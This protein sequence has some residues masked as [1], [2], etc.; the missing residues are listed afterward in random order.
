MRKCMD[1]LLIGGTRFMGPHIVGQLLKHGH[2]LTVFH[3]GNHPCPLKDQITCIHGDRNGELSKI[4]GS[5]DSVIDTC[6]YHRNQVEDVYG[7]LSF[8]KYVFVST[9][10]AYRKSEQ[11]PLRE[12][13][14]PLGSWPLWG[15]YNRGKVECEQFLA[16]YGR[17]YAVVRPVYILGAGNHRNRE[18][19]IYSH[20]KEG[21]KLRIPGDG[22]ARVQFVFVQ[23]VARAI[24]LLAESDA[25]GAYNCCSD[26]VVTLRKLVEE[27]SKIVGQPARIAYNSA[28]NGA[29]FDENEFP[30]ANEDVVCSNEKLQFLGL[31][32]TPLLEGLR[33]DYENYYKSRI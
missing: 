13:T 23:D 18:H 9:A 30:F 12:D 21:K 25:E 33:S 26:D 8:K 32:F 16:E 5:F 4:Q 2:S 29:K 1:I 19:F 7:Q 14:S 17:T 31:K 3:S 22:N 28:T 15:E 6:A 11:L 24:V 10:A 20:L 27:M